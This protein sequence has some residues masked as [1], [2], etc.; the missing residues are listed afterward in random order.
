MWV[1]EHNWTIPGYRMFDGTWVE[2]RYE[3]SRESFPD[4][5]SASD[6]ARE[7]CRSGEFG[8]TIRRPDGSIHEADQVSFG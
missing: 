4:Y 8:H 3:T 1:L 5:D 2:R 6:A 7:L